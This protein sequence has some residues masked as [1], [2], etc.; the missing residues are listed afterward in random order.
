MTKVALPVLAMMVAGVV[1]WWAGIG[2][3]GAGV[4]VPPVGEVDKAPLD[5]SPVS[6]AI[7]PPPLRP[8][9]LPP[10]GT[11][12]HGLAWQI[13]GSQGVVD[14][15]RLMLGQI[16]A[17]GA[18]TVLI[19][20]PGYQ[21]HAGS[22]SFKLDP[23]VTPSKEQW[24]EIFKVA[25]ANGLRVM[26]M[27]IILLSNPRGTEWR[28]VINP[29]NWDDWFEQYTR[30]ITH[31][32]KLAAENNVEVLSVGSELVS[33]EKYTDRW[34]QVIREVRK[35]FPGKL[36]YSAN[37]DHYKVVQYWDDLDLI[38]MTSYYKLASEANPELE[39]IMEEWA[40][41][42]RNILR[43]Q[44]QYDKPLLFTEVGWCSQEGASIEP[45][46]YYY[47]QEAT[48]R[49]HEEQRRC[50]RAFMD[51]WKNIPQV[52][53][54]IWWEWTNTTGGTEDFNYTPKGKPAERELREWFESVAARPATQP[55]NN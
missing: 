31:F 19:S 13:H 42:K 10:E 41:I 28:G 55:S 49:G 48:V 32:A 15:A 51:T 38:G 26:L 2:Q 21:E 11:P 39:A 53:G 30:F 1:V 12:Y 27:P 24:K 7:V 14:Q 54:I 40:P 3:G 22:E 44:A 46:N 50:Y 34:R 9:P 47:K 33:T 8:R 16:A 43:W 6:T 4:P 45:W 52:G 25:H 18:D 23:A 36:T 37:W 17:L 5:A 29:P 20:N 35:V